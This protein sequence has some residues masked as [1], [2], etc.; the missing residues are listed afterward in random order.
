[1]HPSPSY[2]TSK[3]RIM[4]KENFNFDKLFHLCKPGAYVQS[5]DLPF[6][7]LQYINR[8]HEKGHKG[9]LGD[10]LDNEILICHLL[11]RL[12]RHFEKLPKALQNKVKKIRKEVNEHL[13]IKKHKA[14]SGRSILV[15]TKVSPQ[16]SRQIQFLANELQTSTSETVNQL[17]CDA[18]A[19]IAK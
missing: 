19:R 12:E 13:K 7:Y 15:G 11:P 8:I 9:I 3:N 1:M 5:T 6:I 14:R 4:E 18:L 2:Q 17:I 16:T 10:D